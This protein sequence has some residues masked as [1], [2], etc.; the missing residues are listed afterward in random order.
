ML[1]DAG[2][3]RVEKSLGV[4]NLYN[5]HNVDILHHVNQAM[6]AHLLFK[7]DINYSQR[8]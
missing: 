8:W 5:E 7:R 2:V 1:T 3:D 4:E 6:K